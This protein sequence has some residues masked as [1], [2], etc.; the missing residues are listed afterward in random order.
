MRFYAIAVYLFLYAPL[1]VIALFSFSAGRSA[2]DFHGFSV[3]W[4]ATAAGNRFVIE[5]LLNSLL[6]AFVSSAI[7]VTLVVVVVIVLSVAM[8]I[9]YRISGARQVDL[10]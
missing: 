8:R 6:V 3:Q 5:A 1:G 2:S 7:A 4:Y 10:I 9:A